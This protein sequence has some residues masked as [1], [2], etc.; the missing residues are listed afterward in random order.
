MSE[1]ASRWGSTWSAEGLRTRFRP[2]NRISG[3]FIQV[4]P[5]IDALLVATLVALVCARVTL[6]PGVVFGLP[7]AA[8][9]EGS[10]QATPIVMLRVGKADAKSTL[11]FFDSDRYDISNPREAAALKR[12]FSEN[13]SR[14]GGRE[15]LLMA[16][17]DIPHGDV[18]GLADLA[19][20][21]GVGR[22]CV[23]VKPE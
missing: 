3:A 4:A 10:M 22:I 16:D 15:L 17:R 9:T 21:S 23:A 6:K 12:K 14:P 8:F 13:I 1:L 2:R 18:V 20:A 5:W 19:R 11:V 7:R